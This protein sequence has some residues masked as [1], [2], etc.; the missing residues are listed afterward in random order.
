M[1]GRKLRWH[2]DKFLAQ[3]MAISAAGGKGGMK[4]AGVDRAQA[5]RDDREAAD[6]LAAWRQHVGRLRSA[7]AAANSTIAE[8]RA[9]LRIPELGEH[10]AAQAAQMALAAPRPCLVCGLKRDER[11]KGVD[12]A[13]EDSFGEWWV[14]HW[15]HRAC[16]NFWLE[17]EAKL[18]S[19]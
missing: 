5:A 7:V 8:A 10:M 12:V 1:A 4:L 3:G 13:V 14:E 2:R 19:R 11:I 16:R 18:R 6:V 9:H 15:G 17:H